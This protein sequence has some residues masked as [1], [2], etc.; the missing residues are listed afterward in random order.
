MSNR[1]GSLAVV[2]AVGLG[3]LA[4][5]IIIGHRDGSDH[6]SRFP[7]ESAPEVGFVRDMAVHHAQAVEMADAIR[8]RSQDPALITLATDIELGQQGQIGRFYGWL[9]QWGLPASSSEVPMAW[10]GVEA[11]PGMPGA[12]M[13]GMASRDA[14]HQLSEVPTAD[15]EVQFLQLM[16]GHHRGALVMAQAILP[17]TNRE[18]ITRVAKAVVASQTAEIDAMNNL[19]AARGQPPA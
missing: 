19:L 8:I 1:V 18:D 6:A 10:A 9:D 14:V 12:A 7:D 17:L 2:A 5:G 15:A 13:P 3:A 11:M 16:I 4:V